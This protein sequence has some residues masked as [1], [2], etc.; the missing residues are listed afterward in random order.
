MHHKTIGGKASTEVGEGADEGRGTFHSDYNKALLNTLTV[1][2]CEELKARN[3]ALQRLFQPPWSFSEDHDG[4]VPRHA[5]RCPV[6]LHHF[7]ID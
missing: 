5:R 2:V 3:A 1:H 7:D 6:A 4:Q